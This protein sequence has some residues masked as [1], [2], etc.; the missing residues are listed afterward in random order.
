ML[1]E[2]E[3]NGFD[4]IFDP[5]IFLAQAHQVN[6]LE[7]CSRKNFW[8]FRSDN[9]PRKNTRL[10]FRSVRRLLSTHQVDLFFFYYNQNGYLIKERK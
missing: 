7:V 4:C 5:F 3:I 1:P 6:F 10:Y 2:Q 9:C 8:L